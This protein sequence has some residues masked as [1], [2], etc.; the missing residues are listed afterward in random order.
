M[1]AKSNK[2]SLAQLSATMG[3]NLH[4]NY[5]YCT[6]LQYNHCTH[7][8]IHYKHNKNLVLGKKQA[9]FDN[10]KKIKKSDWKNKDIYQSQV[11]KK[12]KKAETIYKNHT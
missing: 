1:F 9:T 7:R 6:N 12:K 5:C 10:N 4:S 3:E 11:K 2:S 8:L